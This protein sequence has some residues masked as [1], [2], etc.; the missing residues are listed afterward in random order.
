[1]R[2]R[3]PR[4][5]NGKWIVFFILAGALVYLYKDSL[6]APNPALQ[7]QPSNVVN[8][9][10][11]NSVQQRII[12][13]EATMIVTR[14]VYADVTATPY[15]THTPQPT[16]TP[17]STPQPIIIIPTPIVINVSGDYG[18][19]GKYDQIASLW[20]P[21]LF[22]LLIL[23]FTPLIGAYTWYKLRREQQ[24]MTHKETMMAMEI[25]RINNAPAQRSLVI[26]TARNQPKDDDYITTS[27]GSKLKKEKVLEFIVN[28]HNIGLSINRW[29][30]SSTSI[31]QG[32]IEIILDHLQAVGLITERANGIAA[33]WKRDVDMLRLARYLG[34]SQMELANH[35]TN[36]D[37]IEEEYQEEDEVY[38][39]SVDL[40]DYDENNEGLPE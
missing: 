30:E 26:N 24:Q 17:Q 14:V 35:K 4:R 28:V 39:D 32:D 22:A 15:P 11:S 8:I 33:Q 1:M 19:D 7:T 2:Q 9:E 6:F 20:L 5:R 13:V 18:P 29:K 40:E 31:H 3:E 23:V 34:V 27:N 36:T 12:P 38:D 16:Y 21:K 37:Q 10:G 25:E